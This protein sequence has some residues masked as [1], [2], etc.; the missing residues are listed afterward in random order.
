MN[1]FYVKKEKQKNCVLFPF[2]GFLSLGRNRLP[3]DIA[4]NSPGS[5]TSTPTYTFM[6]FYLLKQRGQFTYNLGL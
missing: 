4:V 5:Y 2:E 6:A 3:V 1:M